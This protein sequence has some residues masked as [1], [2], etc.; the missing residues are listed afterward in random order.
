MNA[1][2]TFTSRELDYFTTQLPLVRALRVRSLLGA[3]YQITAIYADE[4]VHGRCKY[5][6]NIHPDHSQPLD[7]NTLA[8]RL[9]RVRRLPLDSQTSCRFNPGNRRA[10]KSRFQLRGHKSLNFAVPT[11]EI[12]PYLAFLREKLGEGLRIQSRPR[13]NGFWLA[14]LGLLILGLMTFFLLQPDGG[15]YFAIP[16]G[17]L[18]LTILGVVVYDQFAEVPP[19]LLPSKRRR[20]GKDLSGRE[21]FRSRWLGLSLK[22][23]CGSF[24]LLSL[25]ASLIGIPGGGLLLHL[26]ALLGLYAGH[27]LSQ[28]K[29]KYV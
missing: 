14:L 3:H 2:D 9:R 29:P 17:M 12:E 7:A 16:F 8:K 24:L 25:I 21:P 22:V 23:I 11:H 28:H 6:E 20:V 4:I 19:W 10:R 1:Y 26:I 5:L 18:G 13:M 27:L 15:I